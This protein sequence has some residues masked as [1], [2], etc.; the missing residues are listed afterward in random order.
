[1]LPV[2]DSQEKTFSSCVERKCNHVWEN[3]ADFSKLT[4]YYTGKQLVIT[5]FPITSIFDLSKPVYVSSCNAIFHSMCFE[6]YDFSWILID[7]TVIRDSFK[8][9]CFRVENLILLGPVFIHF[10]CII[11]LCSMFSTMEYVQYY[12]RIP[13]VLCRMFITLEG[14]YL[15]LW[16]AIISTVKDV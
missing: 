7:V 16:R 12:E 4:A 3:A 10:D 15:V 8:F 5:T 11:V 6:P 2:G 9:S 1:M 13:S 14:Y